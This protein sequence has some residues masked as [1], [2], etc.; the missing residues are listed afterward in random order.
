MHNAK[1]IEIYLPTGNSDE[2]EIAQETSGV[3]KV[4]HLNQRYIEE[5]K[6]RINYNGCYILSGKDENEDDLIYIGEADNVF[7]RLKDHK[8]N[9][10]FW[11]DVYVI[12]H[13][14]NRFDKAN[15]H[16]LENLMIKKSKESNRYN[17]ANRNDGQ[18][19]N[20]TE[21]KESESLNFFEDIK[22]ILH[23]LGLNLFKPKNIKEKISESNKF[24]L[25]TPSNN[26]YAEAIY[27]NDELTVLKG[28]IANSEL[29]DHTKQVNLQNKL[30]ADQVIVLEDNKY[31]FKKD[32]TFNSPSSA[33]ALISGVSKNGWDAWKN[34]KNQTLDE[35]YR[36]EK[37]D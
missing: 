28:A 29:K 22:L 9:K 8:K 7:E 17:I 10:D 3:I 31:V 19:N 25:K 37:V 16:Y 21:A 6:A 18:K 12:V 24:Y 26:Y 15:L 34:D 35:L 14:G 30:I 27:S 11:N 33:A 36:N 2:V 13:S 5:N 20:I 23:T 1:N 32:H 4:V